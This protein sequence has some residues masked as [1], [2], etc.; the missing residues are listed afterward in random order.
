MLRPAVRRVGTVSAPKLHS[1]KFLSRLSLHDK[2]STALVILNTPWRVAALHKL[3]AA[4]AFHVCA[5][6]AA[7]RLHDTF[8]D[9]LAARDGLALVHRHMSWY[10]PEAITGDFD[11]V[12]PEVLEHYRH[13]GARIVHDVRYMDGSIECLINSIECSTG[14]AGHA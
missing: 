14:L 6:G 13:R 2:D 11:S 3:W 12:R 1:T 4:S 9:D 10:M 7:N 8:R 5:D